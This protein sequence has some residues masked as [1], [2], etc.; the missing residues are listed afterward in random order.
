MGK[1]RRVLS[2]VLSLLMAVHALATAGE[3]LVEEASVQE[4]IVAEDVAIEEEL[5][6]E[7]MSEERMPEV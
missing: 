7:V 6:E 4:E 3:L 5:P 2:I 1:S